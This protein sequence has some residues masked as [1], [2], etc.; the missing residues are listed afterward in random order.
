MTTHP[1][2]GFGKITIDNGY[3]SHSLRLS[4]RTL[5]R[6]QS[7][8]VMT[9]RGQ[10]FFVEG[11]REQDRWAFNCG[12]VG[13]LAVFTDTGREIYNGQLSDEEVCL[14]TSP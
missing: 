9:L 1:S 5:L 7:G 11:A 12:V 6:I 10:G 2:A 14:E 3:D 4:S 13:N 8:A